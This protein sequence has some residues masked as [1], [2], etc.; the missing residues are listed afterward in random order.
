MHTTR[1][2][3]IARAPL[4]VLTGAA[5]ALYACSFQD[6]DYLQNGRAAEGGAGSGGQAEGGGQAHTGGSG[7]TTQG[8]S[9]G[10]PSQGGST[11]ASGSPAG[12][13]AGA[14]GE[15]GEAGGAGGSATG[16]TAG[17]G[18]GQ[19]GAGGD[20]NGGV[21]GEVI[22]PEPTGNLL[23]NPSFEQGLTGWTVD[24]P[25]AAMTPQRYVYAQAPTTGGTTVDGSQELATW[26][27]L[28]EYTLAV[29][30]IVK[31]LRPPATYSF[32]GNFSTQRTQGAYLFARNC[33]G[34][35]RMV[36]I[37]VAGFVWFEVAIPDIQV[38]A[39][40][41]EVGFSIHNVGDDWVN[42]DMFTFE[43]VP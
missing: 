20:P 18:P 19:G 36:T 15:G 25:A 11:G 17:Q 1:F 39:S 13:D 2:F 9:G 33:G 24:P 6:F 16:G 7:N 4:Q 23:A 27:M 3:P 43:K 41:C 29:S 30:Q 5:F 14:G 35:D 40:S 42:A 10:K 32:K 26:H 34:P 37:P 22:G 38:S 28:D 12:G 21:G 31:N 8:G